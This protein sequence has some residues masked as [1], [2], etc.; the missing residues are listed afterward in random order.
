MEESTLLVASAIITAA[1]T[2]LAIGPT[3]ECTSWAATAAII[4]VAIWCG[5][6]RR[7][8]VPSIFISGPGERRGRSQVSPDR[9]QQAKL[10]ASDSIFGLEHYRE[11]ANGLTRICGVWRRELQLLVVIVD[12]PQQRRAEELH[13]AK[14]AFAMRVVAEVE[15]V[16]GS[17]RR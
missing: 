14:V 10:I 13:V 5:K 6:R 7:R 4:A 9:D 2:W 16:V 15:C 1:D 11:N 8:L 17:R 12:L 3:K